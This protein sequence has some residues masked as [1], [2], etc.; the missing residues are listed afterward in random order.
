MVRFVQSYLKK[1]NSNHGNHGPICS[2]TGQLHKELHQTKSSDTR[3]MKSHYAVRSYPWL[4]I[5]LHAT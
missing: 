5:D 1:K 2:N 4:L 3:I